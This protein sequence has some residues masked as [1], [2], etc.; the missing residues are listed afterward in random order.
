L[1]VGIPRNFP[2][3]ERVAVEFDKWRPQAT[4]VYRKKILLFDI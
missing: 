2:D 1:T 4:M 3:F